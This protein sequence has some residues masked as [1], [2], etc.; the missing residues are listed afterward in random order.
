MYKLGYL[1]IRVYCCHHLALYE[2]LVAADV[3]VYL[4]DL[5]PAFAAAAAV[6]R[7]GCVCCRAH[8]NELDVSAHT[9]IA[10]GVAWQCT[11]SQTDD[12]VPQRVLPDGGTLRNNGG[13]PVVGHMCVAVRT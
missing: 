12:R 1:A 4:G 7:K 10:L 9:L 11:P 13:K 2:C 3:F 6:S 5:R 8:I